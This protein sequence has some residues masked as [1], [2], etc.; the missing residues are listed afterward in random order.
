MV[1]AA[2]M[3]ATKLLT[4]HGS[5]GFRQSVR[6]SAIAC[7]HPRSFPLWVICSCYGALRL[8]RF[9]RR[10]RR[11]VECVPIDLFRAWSRQGPIRSHPDAGLIARRDRFGADRR[12]RWGEHSQ[13]DGAIVLDR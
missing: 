12:E 7:L 8:A 6:A 3:T 5:S 4:L 10:P 13:P 9:D 1:A 11:K 2:A